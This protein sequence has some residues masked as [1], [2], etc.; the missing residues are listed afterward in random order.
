MEDH[1]FVLVIKI[2]AH[3]TREIYVIGAY[4]VV[5]PGLWLWA[6]GIFNHTRQGFVE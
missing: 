3:T 1:Y 2:N 6:L 5:F 4:D